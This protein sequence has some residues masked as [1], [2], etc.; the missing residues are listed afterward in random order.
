MRSSFL[1]AQIRR[2]K[3]E[4]AAGWYGFQGM[5]VLRVPLKKIQTGF[6]C[7]N[8]VEFK[9]RYRGVYGRYENNVRSLHAKN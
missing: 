1:D 2:I 3:F 7:Q 6:M 5:P 8:V 4:A 9:P